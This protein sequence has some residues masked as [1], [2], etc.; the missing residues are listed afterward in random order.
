[1]TNKYKG[2][3]FHTIPESGTLPSAFY[4]ALGKAVFAEGYDKNL[5]MF[6]ESCDALCVET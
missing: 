2:K 3:G 4:R 1:V 5:R 6:R